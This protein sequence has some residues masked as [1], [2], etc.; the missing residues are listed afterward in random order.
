[1]VQDYLGLQHSYGEVDC[2]ELIRSFYK[3]E[4]KLSFPLPTYPKSRDWMK[5]FSTA[6]VDGWASSCAIKVKLT[7]AKNYDVMVFKSDKSDLIIHFSMFLQPTK[8]LHVEEGGISCIETLSTYWLDKLYT[9]YR[10][11]DMV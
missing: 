9:I 6:S 11:N 8:M 4:L 5:H 1:M 10:H 2:I 7:E 3:N